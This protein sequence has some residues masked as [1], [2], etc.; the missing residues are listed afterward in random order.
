[1][2]FNIKLL[3][4]GVIVILLT[5]CEKDPE[6]SKLLKQEITVNNIIGLSDSVYADESL[7]FDEKAAYTRAVQSLYPK[8]RDSLEGRTVGE[9]IDWQ[10]EERQEIQRQQTNQLVSRYVLKNEVPVQLTRFQALTDE[11]GNENNQLTFQVGNTSEKQLQKV[12][13]L[14]KIF[15]NTNNSL[16]KQ[17]TLSLSDPIEAQK[18]IERKMTYLHDSTN[19]RDRFIRENLKSGILRVEWVP[20]T[21]VWADGETMALPR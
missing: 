15:N 7:S 3:I 11:N 14:F 16:I 5:G 6:E 4:F 12:T 8:H 9:L 1:M 20:D 13:G 21:V 2:T 19:V 10:L 18:A 17:Y